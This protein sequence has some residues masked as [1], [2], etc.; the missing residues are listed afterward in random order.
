MTNSILNFS[1]LSP[2]ERM[3]RIHDGLNVRSRQFAAAPLTRDHQ[4]LQH[5]Q[6]QYV[7]QFGMDISNTLV[8]LNARIIRS[9]TLKYNPESRQPSV[10]RVYLF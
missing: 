5:G 2:N 6:S 4:V 3:A 8:D 1:T 9:P 7:H 10:V